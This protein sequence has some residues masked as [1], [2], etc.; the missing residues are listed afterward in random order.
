MIALTSSRVRLVCCGCHVEVDLHGC[1]C[2]EG[3]ESTFTGLGEGI[4]YIV[5]LSDFGGE[6]CHCR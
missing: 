6:P 3:R 4:V 2:G 5:S 1:F